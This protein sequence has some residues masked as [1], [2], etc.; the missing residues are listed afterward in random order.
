LCGIV[1]LVDF[2]KKSSKQVLNEMGDE[3]AHRGPDA[4]NYFFKEKEKYQIGLGHRRLSII[5]LNA[6]AN[7][8]M[9]F[10]DW[11]IIF[12]GEIY[13][14][15][16]LKEELMKRGRLFSTHSDTEVILQAFDEWGEGSVQ[17]F[18]GMFA[19]ILYNR[20]SNELFTVRD[21]AGV[22][23]L[24]CYSKGAI[25]MWTSELK[26][27]HKHPQ[28]EKELDQESINSFLQLGYVPSPNSIFRHLIKQPPGTICRY[29]LHNR[30]VSTEEYWNVHSFYR[31]EIQKI[32]YPDAKAKTKELLISACNYRM[33][34]DVA[35]GVFLSGGYDS[36]LVTAA[37]Q[38]G[39][40]EKI[41]TFTVG[42]EDS[43]LNEAVFAKKIAN[44]LGTNHTEIYL[45]EQEMF[46]QLKDFSF[47]YDEPFG[48][49]SALPTMLVSKSARK[50]VKVALS[51]DG[52][53]EV[54]ARY[55]NYS[56]I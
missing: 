56:H 30:N 40:T 27:F 35:V 6:V 20:R 10:R 18:I 32:D 17:K 15:N 47:Y 29:D 50:E 22:K 37:L 25:L 45:S 38:S 55:D 7:Q 1:G 52:G 3:L 39:R 2:T 11:I 34:A 26:A 41:K 31:K 16:E 28:F 14:Y 5:D 9:F 4:A 24:F 13:N 42:I 8:P 43:K 49:A 12:N 21:R 36:T 23:P 48:D 44:H 51:A 53:D 33:V 46:N 19:F 54:F